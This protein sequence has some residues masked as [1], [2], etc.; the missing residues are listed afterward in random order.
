MNT[1]ANSQAFEPLTELLKVQPP[2]IVNVHPNE[3]PLDL[4][5][6]IVLVLECGESVGQRILATA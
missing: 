6:E 4:S 5:D 1:T 3:N 2:R